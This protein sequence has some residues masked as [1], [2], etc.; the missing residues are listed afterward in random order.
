MS[1]VR[2][3]VRCRSAAREM[4]ENMLY[5]YCRARSSRKYS[6]FSAFPVED[7]TAMHFCFTKVRTSS[8]QA[9][10]GHLPQRGRHFEFQSSRS[11]TSICPTGIFHIASAIFHI[12][13]GNISLSLRENFMIKMLCCNLATEHLNFSATSNNTG[14]GLRPLCCSFIIL[15]P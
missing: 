2:E 1:A 10:L 3:C 5:R 13:A 7:L 14:D 8:D 6:A 4:D 12:S 9:S 11:D 15:L